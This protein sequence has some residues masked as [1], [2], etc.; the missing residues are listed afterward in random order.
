MTTEKQTQAITNLRHAL[1]RCEQEG[2]QPF[3][4]AAAL[5]EACA[6]LNL[7]NG[8]TISVSVTLK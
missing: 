1:Q 8:T 6:S 2:L 7:P 3:E 5:K 4:I